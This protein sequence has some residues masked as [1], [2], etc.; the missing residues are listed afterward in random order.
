V[1]L[2][3]YT[4]TD[5]FSVAG[6][7]FPSDMAELVRLG[8]KSIIINRPD[9]EA[10]QDQPAAA[11]MLQ[12]AHDAG[13]QAAFQPIALGAVGPRE[14]EAFDVLLKQLPTPVLA[15]CKSGGRCLQL[16]RASLSL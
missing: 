12:A 16:Y 7:L 11:V 13:L 10:G 2:P 14:V 6:Q 4:I 3:I 1:A 5:T 8:F 15:Y 9:G